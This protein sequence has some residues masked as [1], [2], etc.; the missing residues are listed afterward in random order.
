MYEQNRI[1]TS[2]TSAAGEARVRMLMAAES[3]ASRS[4]LGRRVCE[5]FGFYDALGRPQQAG[6]MKALRTLDERGRISLP[7]PCNG[8]GGGAPRGLGHP[9]P[10][11]EGVP[12]RVD[13]VEGL[14][15]VLV[16]SDGDRRVWNELMAREHPRGAARH[17][18]AQLRYLLVSDH[19]YLGALGFAASALAL[20]A[21][22]EWIGWDTALRE[23]QLHR[24]VGL[25]RFLIRPS[26]RCRN[27]ASKALGQCLRRLGA[28]FEQH[29]GYRPLLVETFLDPA[30]HNGAS[31]AASNW[32]RVGET[33]GRGRFAASGARVPVKS[34]WVVPLAGNWRRQLGIP[35]RAPVPAICVGEGLDREQ[36][37]ENEFGSAPLGDIRLSRRLVKSAAVQADHPMSSFPAAAQSDKAM[38]MGYYRMID[39]PADSEVSPTNILAPHRARTLQRMQ[40]ADVVLC[41]QD[42][43]DLN[44]A[45]HPGCAG[46][47]L[48]GRNKGSSGTLGLHMH[49]MLAVNGDGIPLGV[50]HI[51]YEAPDGAPEQDKPPEERK[52]RRWVRGLQDCDRLARELDGVRPVSIADREGDLFELFV[53]QRR[54]G[55]VDLLVRAKHNRSLGRKTPKL[56][57]VAQAQPVRKRLEIHVARSSARR[58]TRRQKAHGKRDAR[59]A[60]VDLRWSA[61]ELP[62]PETSGFRNEPPIRLNLVHIHE[63]EP[64]DGVKPLEWFLLTSLPVASDRD[65]ERIL[66]WY[67]LRWRIEDWHRVLKSGCKVEYLGHRTG[68]RIERAV[69]INAVIAWRLTAMTMMGRETPELPADILF[70][71]IEIMA[72]EDFAS[73]RKLLAPGNLGLAVLTMAMLGGYL[74]RKN[75]PWPGHEK[76]WEGYTRLAVAAQTYERLIRM[77]RTSNLYQRLRSDK[78][79]G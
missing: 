72:L 12:S 21:R 74:N 62:P 43:T 32:I 52:T 59:E 25:S 63:P 50:P 65:A 58:G 38:V 29:Y 37:A 51:Q 19:G 56:F 46:L 60:V 2:V 13:A 3:C 18:G 49:S 16:G 33:T 9:V 30:R 61:V 4:A 8:G 7:A 71:D 27:L 17:A 42:G 31:L 66:K 48:I 10:V 14:S 5:V 44:F 22:D 28:D 24:V 55:T 53:E 54:L 6:C 75:D 68:D 40:G 45:E 34:V 35:P 70:S 39:Q 69:T 47:G 57:D 76:I 11:P 64:P 41:I 26:V 1:L 67:R 23:R 79:C 78:T 20:A 36:W 77:D 15:L 73:D